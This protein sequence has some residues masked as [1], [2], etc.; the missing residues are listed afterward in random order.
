LIP[1]DISERER[2]LISIEIL[3][4]TTLLAV[5]EREVGLV[6]PTIEALIRTEPIGISNQ[7]HVLTNRR[8]IDAHIA[9]LCTLHTSCGNRPF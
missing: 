7:I 6:P 1:D 4:I 3:S 2:E 8:A 9:S 5:V